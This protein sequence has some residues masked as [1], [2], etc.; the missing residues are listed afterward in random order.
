MIRLLVLL[1]GMFILLPHADARQCSALH[2][3]GN[4]S[5]VVP[6]SP[7][8]H[9]MDALTIEARFTLDNFNHGNGR[10]L[11]H[12]ATIGGGAGFDYSVQVWTDVYVTLNANP[13]GQHSSPLELGREYHLAVVY[14]GNTLQIYLDGQPDGNMPYNAGPIQTSGDLFIGYTGRA[15]PLPGEYFPGTID[16]V[17]IWSIARSQTEIQAT[18]NM[19]LMGTEPGLEAYWRFDEGAGQVVA[20]ATGQGND[21]QL[22]ESASGDDSDPS[23]VSAPCRA[24][25]CRVS[26][27]TDGKGMPVGVLFVNGSTDR[28]L[29][30]DAGDD[31]WT[32]ML[33]PPAGGNGKFVVHTN[34]GEPTVDTVTI[35]PADIGTV[36]FPFLLQS[37]G[38]PDAVW[39]N[40]GKEHRIGASQYFDGSALPDPDRAPTLFWYRAGGDP[41]YLP[42]GSSVT[43]QGV[44]L[45]PGAESPKLASATN[46]V[47]V[48][49][50]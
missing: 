18:M 9:G 34:L 42:P 44:M 48:R 5:I 17:R 25:E 10:L 31:L 37:G 49:V 3:D 39:N 35:L 21:G 46:G 16:E 1:L 8:L 2:F 26:S 50:R 41:V 12:G 24:P 4:D 33:P 40:V 15:D 20:D 22:G 6:D 28:E 38:A 36:C 14:D 45:D 19:G 47:V 30:V 13:D 43:L 7:N 23:W 11:F 32:V 27:V 29:F